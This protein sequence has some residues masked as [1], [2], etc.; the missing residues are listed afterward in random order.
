MENFFCQFIFLTL[1]E[2]STVHIYYIVLYYI[3][4]DD[5]NSIEC[6]LSLLTHAYWSFPEG[7]RVSQIKSNIK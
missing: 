1:N 2:F 7:L 5:E 6:G 4:M 3:D